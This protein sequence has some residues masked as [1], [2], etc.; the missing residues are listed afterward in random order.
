MHEYFSPNYRIAR[1]KFLA[2]AAGR[3][4]E[5][6][7]FRHP[8]A[9]LEG[10]TLAADVAILGDPA[11]PAVLVMNA[12][13]HGAEGFCGSGVE[14]GFLTS[15]EFERLPAGLRV[16]LIHAINPY[17]FS[18][19]QRETHENVDLNRNFVDFAAPLPVNAG[20]DRL[21]AVIAPRHWTPDTQAARRTAFAG[22]A[23]A[24]GA[25]AL[26]R[27]ITAG[28]YQ[29]P[30]GLFFGGRGPTWSNAT[31]G[32]IVA[33]TCAGARQVGFI[34]FH[35]GLGPYGTA[36]LIAE[37]GPGQASYDRALAWYEHG[38][39]SIVAG[40]SASAPVTGDIG[41]SLSR[42]LPGVA[43]TPVSPE[44]GTVALPRELEAL[45]ARLWV[46]RHGDPHDAF[47]RQ[48][49]REV[50]DCFYPDADD[51]RELIWVRSRQVVSRAIR[52]LCGGTG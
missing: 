30:D 42:A 44:F 31:F 16:V 29:H 2:A 8:Q 49:L 12:A 32:T 22:F 14:I 21:H 6:L 10:E 43:V 33:R 25:A 5:C 39:V 52:G 26:Q 20:Y 4:A 19:L 50:R 40:D 17:G 15:D 28:Q 9:G 24:E 23:A 1:E 37:G 38:V 11:A 48:V 3:R 47:G 46:R 51:W 35:T 13:T 34:D 7:T 41:A 27:A 18:W 45:I 36:E